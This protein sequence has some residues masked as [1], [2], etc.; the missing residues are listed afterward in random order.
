MSSSELRKYVDL[1]R[2]DRDFNMISESLDELEETLWS[3]VSQARQLAR[4]S[5]GRISGPFAAQID[6]YLT[7]WLQNF[8]ED[9]NQPGSLSTLRRILEAER[10][11][12]ASRTNTKI[13]T[14]RSSKE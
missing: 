1:L 5:R 9:D 8:I 12:N 11:Q 7:E 3:A 10:E 13:Q 4:M 2:E 6:N 14:H